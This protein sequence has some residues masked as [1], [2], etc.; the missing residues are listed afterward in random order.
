MGLPLPENI[1]EEAF[2]LEVAKKAQQLEMVAFKPSDEKAKE[3]SKDVEKNI[4]KPTAEIEEGGPAP[5]AQPEEFKD[6]SIDTLKSSFAA[7]SVGLESTSIK[8]EEFEKD[9]DLN[10]HVD[11]IYSLANLRAT[12]YKL[13]EM[14]WITV[15]IKAGR[16]VPALA[17]TTASIA[18]LQTLELVKVLKDI[19]VDDI[20]NAFLNL[21]VPILTQSEPAAPPKVKL[22]EKVSVTLWDRWEIQGCSNK[23]LGDIFKHIETEFGLFARDVI[24]GAKSIYMRA[25][26]QQRPGAQD[27]AWRTIRGRQRRT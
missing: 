4:K 1:R 26:Q 21:A 19:K 23:T 12:N 11:A 6:E 10:Y 7:S 27:Q 3:I 24:Q 22:T 2:K 14:D 8:P 15:K 25:S 9:N 17:T 18:G 16:I 13:D 5:I 20:K